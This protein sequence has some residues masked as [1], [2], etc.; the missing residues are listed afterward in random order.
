MKK[1]FNLILCVILALTFVISGCSSDKTESSKLETT[2]VQETTQV[3]TTVPN[4]S[5]NDT[6]EKNVKEYD[7]VLLKQKAD[8]VISDFDTIISS[9][10]YNGATY[11]KIE[12]DF[13]YIKTSGFSNAGKHVNNSINTCYYTGSVTK[14]FTATAVMQLKEQGKLSLDDTLKKYFPSYKYAD[15]ITVRN[16]LTM[17]SGIK[18]YVL[19]YN[20]EDDYIYLQHDLENKISKDNS[21]NEIKEKIVNWILSQE[22][23]FE[24]DTEYGYS[25]SNYYLL[26]KVIEKASGKTYEKYISE[27]I[28]KPLGLSCSGFTGSE[29]LSMSYQGYDD[30]KYMTYLGVGYSSSGLISNVSDLLKWTDGLLS[31]QILSEDSVKEMFTPN[32]EN[33]GYG[34]YISGNR[35]SVYGNTENYSSSFSYTTDKSEIFVSLTNYYDS[36]PVYIYSLFKQ[37]LSKFYK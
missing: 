32:K 3:A 12:N 37:T 29:H 26:G 28:L 10:K 31:Y 22:L 8:E 21:E 24:P 20:E 34:V 14:Q 7:S 9:K 27:N 18:N 5:T 25:D 23:I 4:V 17:T 6:A 33:Y 30:C 16:L 1:S 11:M 35:I 13:E 36:D 2:S 15:K 19:R